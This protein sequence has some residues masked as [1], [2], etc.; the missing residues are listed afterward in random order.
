MKTA[1]IIACALFVFGA[2][3]QFNDPDPVRWV[4]AYL[5]AAG[6]ALAALLGREVTWLATAAGAAFA[7][8]ALSFTPALGAAPLRE[9]LL[10]EMKTIEIEEAR[11][12]LGLAICATWMA[13]LAGHGWFTRR[14]RAA[15]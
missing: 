13:V 9:L 6:I 2:L 1:G 5:M 4:I 8:G 12:A 11:E 15:N 14:S 7:I 10:P 3:V